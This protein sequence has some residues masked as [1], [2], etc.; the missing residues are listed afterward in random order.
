VIDMD[1]LK[2]FRDDYL[3]SIAKGESVYIALAEE[4]GVNPVAA[5][6]DLPTTVSSN[7]HDQE[8]FLA[9]LGN[10][11]AEAILEARGHFSLPPVE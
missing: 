6:S 3:G 8:H 9:Y 4:A 1:K 5:L 10:D 7:W 2:E 11:D